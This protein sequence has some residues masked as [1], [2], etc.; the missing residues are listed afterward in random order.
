M[1]ICMYVSMHV[2]MCMTFSLSCISFAY[3]SA[4]ERYCLQ[5]GSRDVIFSL[6]LTRSLS[7]LALSSF[8]VCCSSNVTS[9][10]GPSLSVHMSVKMI[11][12]N[13]G[14][15]VYMYVCI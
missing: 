9:P 7:S 11:I 15:H 6:T 3:L 14:M 1:C 10:N 4:V 13:G 8:L 12:I 2:Y 5:F